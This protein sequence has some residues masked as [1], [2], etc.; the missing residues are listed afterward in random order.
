VPYHSTAKGGGALDYT[1]LQERYG[2]QFVAL[3]DGEVVAAAPTH[4]DVVRELDAKGI[5]VTK[6]VFEFVRRKDRAYAF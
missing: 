1:E 6:V 3:R 2:G 4:G 5:D